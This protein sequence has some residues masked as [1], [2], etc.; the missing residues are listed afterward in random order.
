MP[1]SPIK[2]SLEELQIKLPKQLTIRCSSKKRNEA[3]NNC[4][5]DSRN[6]YNKSPL[7]SNCFLLKFFFLNSALLYLLN[8]NRNRTPCIGRSGSETLM[9][10]QS[11]PHTLSS[12]P[13]LNQKNI[14][15]LSIG[16]GPENNLQNSGHLI[17]T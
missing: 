15:M 12:S 7:L 10:A 14:C 3:K 2:W 4:L 9:R 13:C 8:S 6:T 17:M 5:I 16:F 11:Y 1:E